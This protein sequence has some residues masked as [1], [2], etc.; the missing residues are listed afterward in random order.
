MVIATWNYPAFT[1]FEPVVSAIAAG[2]AIVMKPS[3]NAP[4]CSTAMRKMIERM[5][6]DYF[7]CVEGG[8]DLGKKLIQMKWDMIAFT[9]GSQI[10]KI[11]ASEA[12]KNLVPCVLELGG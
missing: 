1:L 2:N 5:D 11:V 4:K 7:R 9:G 6:Q 10:G 8:P 12:G 3:E